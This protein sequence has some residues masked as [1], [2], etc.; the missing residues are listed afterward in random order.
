[1]SKVKNKVT[2]VEANDI[3]RAIFYNSHFGIINFNNSGKIIDCNERVLSIFE[4]KKDV[5]LKI[6]LFK[7]LSDEKL[8]SEIKKSLNTGYVYYEGIYNSQATGISTPIIAHCNAVY[9]E[10]NE[11]TGGVIL[12]E[13]NTKNL[14]AEKKLKESE[15]FLKEAQKIAHVGH[16]EKNLITNEIHRSKELLRIYN[17]DSSQKELTNIHYI[18][19]AIKYWNSFSLLTNIYFPIELN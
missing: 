1:M 2:N 4:I 6:N 13:D 10:K 3:Y 8:S 7:D 12:I 19:S 17:L 14:H 15:Q 18:S 5:L 9:S 16:W 11:L